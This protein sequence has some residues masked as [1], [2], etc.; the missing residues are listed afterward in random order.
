MDIWVVSTFWRLWIMLLWAFKYN[1]LCGHIFSFLLGKTLGIELL[2]CISIFSFT[3]KCQTLFQSG[4]ATSYFH[5]LF[6]ILTTFGTISLLKFSYLPIISFWL[7]LDALQNTIFTLCLPCGMFSQLP[8]FFF[9]WSFNDVL[10]WLQNL[11][12]ILLEELPYINLGFYRNA[13]FPTPQFFNPTYVLGQCFL[14]WNICETHLG[15]FQIYKL[16]SHPRRTVS[17]SSGM[18]YRLIMYV[19]K[20]P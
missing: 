10:Y 2:N 16:Q 7:L 4:C 1:C 8:N 14:T 20:V 19:E 17:T 15:A 13:T 12:L 5:Q 3:R 18:V 6:P 11:I 9:F